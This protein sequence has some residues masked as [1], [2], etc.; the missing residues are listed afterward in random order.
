MII[1]EQ[2]IAL[3]DKAETLAEWIESSESFQTYITTKRAHAS[4]RRGA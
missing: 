4:V 3:L 2:T 1:T